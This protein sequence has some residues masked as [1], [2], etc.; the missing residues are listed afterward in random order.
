MVVVGE[1]G[2]VIIVTTGLPTA[3]VHVPVPVPAI[4]AV[5]NW[6]MTWSGPAV[7]FAVTVTSIVSLHPFSDQNNW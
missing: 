6:Q 3:A 4:T 2:V 1:E 5:L 7:G